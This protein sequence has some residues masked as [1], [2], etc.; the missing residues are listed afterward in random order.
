MANPNGT[1]TYPGGAIVPGVT[2]TIGGS[3]G[4]LLYDNNGIIGEATVGANLTLAGGVLSATGGGGSGSP[5]GSNTQIQFNDAGAFNGASGLTWS[6]AT[7]VLTGPDSGTWSS[8]GLASIA[9]FNGLHITSSTGTLTVA[10]GKTLT[11]SNTLTFAGTDGSSVAFGA[12]G[13]VLYGNQTITLSGD[14]T[15]SGTTAITTALANIPNDTTVAG[16]V[17][18]TN[19]VQPATPAG[20]KT[21]IYVDST[22][23]NASAINDAGTVS[24]MVVP[25]TAAS[26]K[27]ATAV[28]AAGVITYTQPA[29]SDL[30]D[31]LTAHAVVLAEGTGSAFAYATIG[32]AGRILIDQGAAADPAF[33][34]LSG[35]VASVSA[36][37][38]VV[39]AQ[40]S[41]FS[42]ASYN[43]AAGDTLIAQT[44]TMSA[45]RTINLVAANSVAAGRRVKIVD[46]S[47]SVT[48]AFYISVAPNGTDKIEGSNTTQVATATAYGWIEIESDGSANWTCIDRSVDQ[49][50]FTANGTLV[51]VIGISSCELVGGAGGGGGGGG[52]MTASGTANS[53]GGGGGGGDCYPVYLKAADL[54]ATNTVTVG[55]NGNGGA[56]RTTAGVGNPGTG[57]GDTT[58]VLANFTQTWFAGGGGGAG[59]ASA[60]SSKGGG[61]AGSTGDGAT[62]AVTAGTNGGTNGGNGVAGVSNTNFG[63]GA[64]GGGSSA[65][66]GGLAGGSTLST[67]SMGGAGGGSGGGCTSTPAA[68]NGGAGG[69]GGLDQQAAPTG[70]NGTGVNGSNGRSPSPFQAGSGGGGGWG[71]GSASVAGT[72]G[73]TGGNCAGGGGGGGALTGA[74]TTGAG[75]NGGAGFL[76]A[77]QK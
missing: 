5:G 77:I 48:P 27:Y 69:V 14:V 22:Q 74:S 6:K 55:A 36:A 54:A 44:G 60:S 39:I 76:L 35:D 37:G 25:S 9:G 10:N 43:M 13:T 15:G 59:Q 61:G 30:S 41:T 19:I 64:G 71:S 63:C 49:Q 66:G 31:S 3:N 53:G 8:A 32:T 38:A 2:V 42:N 45:A 72:N 28:S 62:G 11:A 70:G 21:R 34:A 24:V 50:F 51:K 52:A 47:G 26:H 58:V 67:G 57:G 29:S 33:K 1:N 23:K 4:T 20:G 18:V 73:G 40:R 68:N 75:G 46:E 7:S 16:D 12:G 65:S 17:L 56:A